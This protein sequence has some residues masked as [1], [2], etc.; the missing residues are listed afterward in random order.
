VILP[1]S[2]GISVNLRRRLGSPADPV[3][4]GALNGPHRSAR[5]MDGTSS[6][7]PNSAPIDTSPP[8]SSEKST[9]GKKQ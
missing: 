9:Q 4:P 2:R 1:L 7:R 8:Y 3:I 6:V 5:C